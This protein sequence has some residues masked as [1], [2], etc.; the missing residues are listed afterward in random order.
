VIAHIGGTVVVRPHADGDSRPHLPAD[1]VRRHQ[2][3]GGPF[4]PVPGARGLV[5]QMSVE[6]VVPAAAAVCADDVDP[7]PDRDA[8]T[9]HPVAAEATIGAE[10]AAEALA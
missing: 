1:A 5:A 9:A 3:I 6:A 8:M 7:R 4:H 10:A 2:G